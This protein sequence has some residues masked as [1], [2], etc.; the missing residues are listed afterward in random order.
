M[1]R[2]PMVPTPNATFSVSPSTSAASRD[3]AELLV[4][5]L[6]EAR[7]VPLALILAPHRER[8]QPLACMRISAY[9]SPGEDDRVDDPVPPASLFDSSL[10]FA[11]P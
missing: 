5:G 10:R 1:V 8:R 4:H 6:A 11:K 9:S 3:R 2:E 7:L